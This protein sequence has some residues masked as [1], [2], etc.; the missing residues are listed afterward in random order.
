[1]AK[2]GQAQGQ[3]LDLQVVGLVDAAEARLHAVSAR[4]S[5]LAVALSLAIA[6]SLALARAAIEIRR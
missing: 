3:G 6:L 4:L 5:P 2:D 1:M